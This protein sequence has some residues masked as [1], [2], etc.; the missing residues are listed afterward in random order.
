M[1]ARRELTAERLR[2][3]LDDDTLTGTFRW[4]SRQ[5]SNGDWHH[6]IFN[7]RYAGK[8]AG[9]FDAHAYIQITV[10]RR[11]YKAH[12]LAWLWVHGALLAYKEIDHR[13]RNP[14]N[15]AV[16]NLRLATRQQQAC[17]TGARKPG[18]PK[19]CHWNQRNRKWSAWIYVNGRKLSLGAFE[20]LE[21]AKAARSQAKAKY[22]GEWA[23]TADPKQRAAA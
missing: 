1:R 7:T 23:Y 19:G 5:A 4:R 18:H 6:K 21:D 17:N 14:A 12:R 8:R 13:D 9:C 16:R 20:R 2:E 15:N 10:D 3:L 22:H 11:N